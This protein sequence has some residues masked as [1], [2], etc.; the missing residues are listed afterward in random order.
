MLD[1]GAHRIG[2]LRDGLDRDVSQFV[3]ES[4]PEAYNRM[5]CGTLGRQKDG[6]DVRRPAEGFGF[7]SGPIIK[8]QQMQRLRKSGGEAIQPELERTAGEIGQCEKATR[9]R[10][11]FDGAIEIEIIELGHDGGHR[12]H[13]AGGHPAPD[14]RQEAQAGFVLRNDLERGARRVVCA[15]RHEHR[16]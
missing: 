1:D 10:G 4:T 7:V 14:D 5:E 13:P 12:L 16:G 8:D 11:W 15:L 3:F 2:Q 6:Y 9:A